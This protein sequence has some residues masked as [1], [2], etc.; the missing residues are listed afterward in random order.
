[1][2]GGRAGLLR[3]WSSRGLLLLLGLCP[4]SHRCC[5]ECLVVLPPLAILRPVLVGRLREVHALLQL[6]PGGILLPV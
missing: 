2:A 3:S 1:M 6:P 4:A 5:C